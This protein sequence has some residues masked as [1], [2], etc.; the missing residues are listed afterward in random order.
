[1][2][3]KRAQLLTILRTKVIDFEE[4]QLLY[5]TD[6][7][8]K[9]IWEK[10]CAHMTTGDFFMHNGFLF[11]ANRLCIPRSSHC[12]HIIEELHGGKLGGHMGRATTIEL[13]VAKYFFVIIMEGCW[14]DSR[15]ILNLSNN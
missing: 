12:E 2:L 9:Q 8:F 15:A 1:M 13:V 4:L 6:E 7:D 14:K 5:A 10:Y 3:S 11:K